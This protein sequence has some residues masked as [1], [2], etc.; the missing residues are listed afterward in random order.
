[1]AKRVISR[2][3]W[4]LFD[5]S[6]AAAAAKIRSYE[7]GN[8]K[9]SDEVYVLSRLTEN[10]V[11]LRDGLIE[12]KVRTAV[13][14]Y[15]LEQWM[16]AF[17]VTFPLYGQSLVRLFSFFGLS[18]PTLR[19]QCYEPAS[20]LTELINSS[21]MLQQVRVTKEREIYVINQCIVEIVGVTFDGN[22][23]ATICVEHAEPERVDATVRQLGLDGGENTG[24]VAALKR[25]SGMAR[26]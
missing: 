2:W 23:H 11:K 7:R 18:I 12:V 1:M 6:F 4:R 20:F 19:R 14:Q 15:G 26:V 8:R 24:Y 22:P 16:P 25:A 3:E 21:R 13:N 5:G 10:N 17:R 9:S